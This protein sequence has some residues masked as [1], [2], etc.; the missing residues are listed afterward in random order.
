MWSLISPPFSDY[1]NSLSQRARMPKLNR[2][3]LLSYELALP[4]VQEQRRVVSCLDQLATMVYRLRALQIE[5]QSHLELLI[6]SIFERA[7]QG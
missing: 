2:V 4:L 6:P 1:A 3:Q 5:A 7:F